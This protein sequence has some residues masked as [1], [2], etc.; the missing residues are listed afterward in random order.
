MFKLNEGAK[1]LMASLSGESSAVV[2]IYNIV[3][4]ILY[5]HDSANQ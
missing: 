1:Y 2:H 5:S 3:E 4:V